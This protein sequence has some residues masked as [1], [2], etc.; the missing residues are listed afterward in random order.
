MKKSGNFLLAK[1]DGFTLIE[2]LVV[3][4]IIAILAALLLPVLSK[5]KESARTIQC[6]NNMKQLSLAWVVYA[7]DNDDKIALNW[8]WGQSLPGS[9]VTGNL[10]WADD[11]DAVKNG[12]LYPYCKSLA[13]YQCPDRTPID[14]QILVRT[15]SVVERM[16][17]PDAE[18]SAEYTLANASGDLGGT[19]SMFKELSQIRKPNPSSAAVFVDES[20][21]SI[22]DG[23]YALDLTQ[24]INSPTIRHNKGASLSFADG[25]AERW[26]WK[27]LNEEMG[28]LVMPVGAQTNDFQRLLNA[29]IQF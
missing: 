18:E 25:H 3:I 10:E 2:L 1:K 23:D 17:G 5:A 26:G 20:Q 28:K 9:W 16:G 14:N 29:E 21:N 7:G 11:P 19:N 15:V 8:V 6:V 12:T 13:I 4:A 24:F 27:G 22:D